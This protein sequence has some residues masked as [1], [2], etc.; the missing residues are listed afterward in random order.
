MQEFNKGKFVFSR[1]KKIKLVD[2]I[3]DQQQWI[4][5]CGGT[6]EGYIKRY[7]AE[8][9]PGRYG[10]GGKAIYES[11]IAYLNELLEKAK[12]GRRKYL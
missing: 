5:S 6:L 9:D 2:A 8:D 11:D 4:E 1:R 7:G 3:A 12:D 10:N